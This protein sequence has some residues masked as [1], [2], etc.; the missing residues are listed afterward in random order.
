ML[1]Q[2]YLPKFSLFAAAVVLALL[3]SISVQAQPYTASEIVDSN[4]TLTTLQID[5]GLLHYASAGD[6]SKP[7]VLF[8]HGTP[9]DWPAF[10]V[11]LEDRSLRKDFFLV[12]VDR[13]GWGKSVS[14]NRSVEVDFTPQARSIAA[15]MNH[16]PNKQ[17]TIVGHSLGASIAPQIALEAPQRVKALLLLAGSLDPSLGKPRWYNWAA[18]TWLVS[19]LI[20]E[21]MRN[22][23]REIMALRQEL[24][25]MNE[26]IIKAKLP[27]QLV[28]M[29][30]LKDK[31]VSPKN[32]VFAAKQ[33]KHNFRSIELIDLEEEGHFLPWRQTPLVIETIRS[34][35][36]LP[37]ESANSSTQ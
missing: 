35:N 21:T 23:N 33:W 34:L 1:T 10:E 2:S 4:I 14:V 32:P 31:L 17:W 11:Y 3:A 9:G 12:S 36:S 27:T 24:K 20:G 18:S 22:S 25:E 19:K 6:P 15:L 5:Q 28:V 37:Q 16:F 29:Q 8:V 30:G 7:G 26:A 13:L